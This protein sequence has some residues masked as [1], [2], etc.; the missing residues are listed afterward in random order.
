MDR[1][2]SNLLQVNFLFKSDSQP[3]AIVE[4]LPF[5]TVKTHIRLQRLVWVRTDLV[6]KILLF[7]WASNLFWAYWA[8]IKP[9]V[10]H[11]ALDLMFNLMKYFLLITNYFFHI[12]DINH[13]S[14]LLVALAEGQRRGGRRQQ[15]RRGRQDSGEDW[16]EIITEHSRMFVFSFHLTTITA[17]DVKIQDANIQSCIKDKILLPYHN[18][19]KYWILTHDPTEM[20]IN[21]YTFIRT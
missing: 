14:A 20:L 5:R 1:F 19:I 17:Q 13:F 2:N 9:V 11:L 3:H 15:G 8:V 7:F 4:D 6:D 16:V 18:I 12:S 21:I 10:N